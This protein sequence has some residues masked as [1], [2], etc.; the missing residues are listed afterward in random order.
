MP[1]D[2]EETLIKSA[3]RIE[4]LPTEATFIVADL[5]SLAALYGLPISEDVKAASKYDSDTEIEIE[6]KARELEDEEDKSFVGAVLTT[7]GN[8]LSSAASS[9]FG[10][11]LFSYTRGFLAAGL[12]IFKTLSVRTAISVLTT[13]MTVTWNVIRASIEAIPKIFKFIIRSASKNPYLAAALA[14]AGVTAAGYVGYKY[15]SQSKE[16]RQANLNKAKAHLF[17]ESVAASPYIK[18][19]S[20]RLDLNSSS[21]S[22]V[23][24]SSLINSLD[25]PSF[26]DKALNQYFS[27]NPNEIPSEFTAQ[28]EIIET[29]KKE[30]W[31]KLDT[32]SP[33][34]Y[35][36]FGINFNKNRSK[37][38]IRNLTAEQ[39]YDIYKREYWDASGVENLPSH[40]RRMYFNTAVNLGVRRAKE[41]YRQSDGTLEG[42]ATARWNYYN[43]LARGNPERYGRYLKGW[44]RRLIQ[45]YN[46]SIASLEKSNQTKFANIPNS[47]VPTKKNE[48]KPESMFSTGKSIYAFG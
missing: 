14:V 32:S 8:V 1:N 38:F 29:M 9:I 46:E 42:L 18:E 19:S 45:E 25:K 15:Y 21:N 10:K 7:L 35:S 24:D 20:E 26:S 31:D 5:S 40:L 4:G 39:A 43:K 12:T 6:A 3:K 47:E 27:V 28:S 2:F 30:G 16:E 22:L 13:F 23:Y 11:T 36:K 41:L 34:N 33:D 48:I 17:G 37:A 44:R